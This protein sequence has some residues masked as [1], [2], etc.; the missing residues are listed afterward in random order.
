VQIP[1]CHLVGRSVPIITIVLS[2]YKPQ[3]MVP[4]LVAKCHKP[5][6]KGPYALL[7]MEEVHLF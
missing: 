2:S 3:K 6:G 5:A 4:F 1:V 7:D